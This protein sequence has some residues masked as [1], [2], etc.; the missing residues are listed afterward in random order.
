[1]KKQ[2]VKSVPITEDAK[3]VLDKHCDSKGLKRVHFLSGMIKREIIGGD[4]GAEIRRRRTPDGRSL[5]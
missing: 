2:N 1:M 4:E 5:F 3:I